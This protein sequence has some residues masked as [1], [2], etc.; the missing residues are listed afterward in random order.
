MEQIT[1]SAIMWHVQD[2][3]AKVPSQHEFMKSKSC[4]SNPISYDKVTYLEDERKAM[5]VVYPDFR[6][7][8]FQHYFSQHSS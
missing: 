5:D 6:K 7:A 2:N 3:Q 1:F 4:L 8:G